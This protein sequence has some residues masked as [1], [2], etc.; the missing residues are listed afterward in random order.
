MIVKENNIA[1]VRKTRQ[2]E[3]ILDVLRNTNIHPTADWIYEK[4]REKC[5]M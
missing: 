4:V 1:K 2:R 5:R 3:I